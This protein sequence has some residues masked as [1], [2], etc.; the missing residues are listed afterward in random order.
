MKCIDERRKWSDAYVNN[1]MAYP[2]EY[3]I[4]IFKGQYPNL[5][6]DKSL[7]SSQKVL[8]AGCG[9]GRN[10]A[11]MYH[12]GLQCYGM[13]IDDE[14]VE[15]CKNNLKAVSIEDVDIRTGV[16]GE[17]P[18]DDNMFDYLLSWNSCYYTGGENRFQI[19]CRRV[20]SCYQVRGQTYTVYS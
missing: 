11:M 3:V 18:F 6:F 15:A 5:N 2:S 13:E 7:Y 8:D 12:C 17:I 14:I 1:R 20:S 16:N 19:S 4:R 9:D 10:I